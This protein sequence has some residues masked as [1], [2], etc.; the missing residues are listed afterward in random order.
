MYVLGELWDHGGGLGLSDQWLGQLM[1]CTTVGMKWR[2]LVEGRE[3]E[4]TTIWSRVL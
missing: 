1:A 3:G 2:I 4:S